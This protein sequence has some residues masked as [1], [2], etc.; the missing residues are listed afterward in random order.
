M[1][2]S[3]LCEAAFLIC[4][5]HSRQQVPE[6]ILQTRE[7]GKPLNPPK[8]LRHN[9]VAAC[10]DLLV[11]ESFTAA[12]TMTCEEEAALLYWSEFSA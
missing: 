10:S 7:H 12:G 6:T 9:T 1:L 11:S 4:A 5:C 3:I 8:H 2:R